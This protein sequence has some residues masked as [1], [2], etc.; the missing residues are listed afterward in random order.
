[1]SRFIY[2]IFY[3]VLALGFMKPAF[4]S[5]DYTV[6][7]VKVLTIDGGIGPAVADYIDD[8]IAKT[9]AS[10][11][12]LIIIQLNT[13][14]GLLTST[15]DLVQ[16]ILNAP[17]PTVVFV[18]PSGARAASAGTF[19]T[20]AANI[21]AMA[22]GTNIGAATPV[23]MGGTPDPESD[24]DTPSKQ[25]VINDSKAFIQSL[26]ERHDRNA[27]WPIKA[28]ESADSLSASQAYEKNVINLMA[29]NVN[30]LV[31]Q[32]NH[33]QLKFQDESIQ[34]VTDQANIEHVAPNF[35]Q[36]LLAALTS[37]TLTY[38][39]LLIGIYGIIF[40]LFNPGL[41]IPGVAGAISLLLAIYGLQML[42]VTLTGVLLLAVGIGLIITEIFVASF[43][44]LAIG[45][46]VAFF[47]GSVMLFDPSTP[48]FHL[49]ISTALGFTLA[50]AAF[51]LIIVRIAVNSFKR[52]KVSSSNTIATSKGH[53][54]AFDGHQGTAQFNGEIW[55]IQSDEP[56]EKGQAVKSIHRNG[57]T[58]TVQ[59]I[60]NPQEE[61]P[62]GN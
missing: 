52:K 29:N 45:G 1:M 46:I 38:I 44:I 6:N 41:I 24:Q 9:H 57:L 61:P 62:H 5:T 8:N 13:P 17:V 18:A 7:Q 23:S 33:Y 48:G 31:N 34:L 54:L 26:A 58:L 39:L 20:Y 14:G 32:L 60:Q 53:V 49:A 51:L 4:A 47:I 37:P 21:A 56:L 3:C 36:W 10:A 30:D 43:G 35:K 27:Q 12:E 42:P 50:T 28:I 55:R 25:K 19:I 2:V 22:P 11:H 16:S 15:R 59:S 40:E